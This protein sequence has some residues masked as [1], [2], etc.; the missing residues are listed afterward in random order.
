[1]RRGL[2]VSGGGLKGAF[3]GG[4]VEYLIKEKNVSWDMYAGTSIGSLILTMVSLSNIDELKK[5][6]LNIDYDDIFKDSAFNFGRVNIFNIIYRLI[7]KKNSITDMKKVRVILSNLISEETYNE[8]KDTIYSISSNFNTG[9]LL[10]TKNSETEYNDFLDLVIASASIPVVFEPI[11]YKG[12]YLFDGGVFNSLPLQTMVDENCDE[13]DVIILKP[14]NTDSKDW[15]PSSMMTVLSK[16]LE[17][18]LRNQLD[19]SIILSQLK[20]KKDVK[21]NF[22]Y[23]DME[24]GVLSLDNMKEIWDAG[25][26]YCKKEKKKNYT[27]ISSVKKEKHFSIKLKK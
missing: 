1:M 24:S 19:T 12:D 22:Y 17:L 16:S 6:F 10:E 7:V 8:N 14:E 15:K 25:Y 2:V 13:I 5:L 4:L 21:L 26:N 27:K 18:L 11:Q 23:D 3:S 9:E 20:L